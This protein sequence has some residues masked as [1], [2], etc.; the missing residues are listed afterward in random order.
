MSK[1]THIAGLVRYDDM[2]SEPKEAKA[3]MRQL[4]L[5]HFAK[6]PHGSEGP[7]EH[8]IVSTHEYEEDGNVTMHGSGLCDVR[9][10]GDLR[11][12]SEED[13]PK[14]EAWF[15]EITHDQDFTVRQGILL[16]ESDDQPPFNQRV[17]VYERK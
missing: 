16:I 13:W 7:L 4:E 2:I 10:A 5:K 1:W 12:F 17:L 11:D 6:V 15:E 14:L 9:I 3:L 8:T